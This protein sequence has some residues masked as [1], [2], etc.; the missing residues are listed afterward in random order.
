M[1]LCFAVVAN[2]FKAVNRKRM[3]MRRPQ[4]HLRFVVALLV[5]GFSS[6]W[7]NPS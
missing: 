1:V 4:I 6:I 5:S 7:K 2:N 3:Y